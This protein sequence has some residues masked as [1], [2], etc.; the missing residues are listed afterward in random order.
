MAESSVLST[1]EATSVARIVNIE[2][3][4]I[5]ENVDNMLQTIGGLSTLN[6]TF[7]HETARLELRWRPNDIYSHS[8][9]GD[10]YST[11]NLL[12]KCVKKK[13]RDENGDVSFVYETAVVGVIDTSY[14]FQTMA[15]FQYLPMVRTKD[16]N[17]GKARYK[18]I[19]DDIIPRNPFSEPNKCFDSNAPLFILPT[20]FSRF[21]MPTDYFFRN[22]PKYRDVSVIQEIERQN[23]SSIIGRTRKSRSTIACL[24]CWN[25]ETPNEPS[26]PV[27][28]NASKYHVSE[29]L[30]EEVRKCFETRPIWSRNALLY[31]LKC[32]RQELRLILPCIAYYFTNGPFR[33]MW[34]RFSYDPRKD[35]SS[36]IYQTLDFRLKQASGKSNNNERILAKRSIYQYQLPLKKND[37]EKSR[38]RYRASVITH[39]SFNPNVSLMPSTSAEDEKN[40]EKMFASFAFRPGIMPACRQQYYQLCDI[41][42]DQVQSLIH[43]NDGKEPDVCDEKDGW[44]IPGTIEHIRAIMSSI[45][46][47]M[48]SKETSTVANKDNSEDDVSDDEYLEYIS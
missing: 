46:D 21:D 48:L 7:S 9:F 11:N 25:D 34:I 18:S 13:K 33:C 31:K 32:T 22:D 10:R 29:K 35:K 1:G 12:V 19:I 3:P 24:L 27:F 45:V 39:D 47:E 20:L 6:R 37:K 16:S 15:D 42:V 26:G 4:A 2:Y 36:K 8:A 28:E 41:S 40:E 5:V 17:E 30:M 14:K 38:N 23:Q 43:A 44:C